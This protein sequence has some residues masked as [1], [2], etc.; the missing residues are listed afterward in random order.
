MMS[1]TDGKKTYA[2]GVLMAAVA[3]ARYLGWLTTDTYLVAEGVLAGGGLIALRASLA[4][5]P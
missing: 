3:F 5:R 2:L 1:L 4:R